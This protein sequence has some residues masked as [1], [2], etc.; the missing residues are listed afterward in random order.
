MAVYPVDQRTIT[1]RY[2]KKAID[3]INGNDGTPF[4]L[5]LAQTMPHTPLA[6]SDKH[7][8][9]DTSDDLYHDVIPHHW[10]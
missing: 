5:Y 2:T 10:P 7:Y 8:T 6:V 3:F 4:F 1:T 9:P